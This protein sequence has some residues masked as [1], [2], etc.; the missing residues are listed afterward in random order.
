M[1]VGRAE[2]WLRRQCRR[3]LGKRVAQVGDQREPVGC[4]A[5]EQSQRVVAGEGVGA[6]RIFAEQPGPVARQR[7]LAWQ[8]GQEAKVVRPD[9]RR[10]G[11]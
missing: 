1:R 11:R 9:S 5:G 8:P 2:V 3:L 4:M 6:D 10:L 7:R